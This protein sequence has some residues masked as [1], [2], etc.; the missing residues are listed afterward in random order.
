MII[1]S[2]VSNQIS[3]II[4]VRIGANQDSV[5]SSEQ[6]SSTE[7]THSSRYLL[8]TF[9]IFQYYNISLKKFQELEA[10]KYKDDFDPI[11]DVS[12]IPSLVI[13]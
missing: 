3:T 9:N 2:L 4:R 12:L 6:F 10:G 1:S 11:M 7:G 13:S 8:E 5:K